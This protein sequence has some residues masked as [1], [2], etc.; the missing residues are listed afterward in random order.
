MLSNSHGLAPS[1]LQLLGSS[2]TGEALVLT[3]IKPKPVCP[4]KRQ[5]LSTSASQKPGQELQHREEH[6]KQPD[7]LERFSKKG[8]QSPVFWINEHTG[9]WSSINSTLLPFSICVLPLH[10]TSVM[11]TT[12]TSF[13]S[14]SL[15][16]DSL[17]FPFSQES[18][19]LTAG[20]SRF[21]PKGSVSK[22]AP[23]SQPHCCCEGT[24][25]GLVQ[26]L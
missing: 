25:K 15:W 7:F 23:C 26:P 5:L 9:Y 14:L 3:D 18:Q 24:S 16:G 6:Q 20:N 12:D 21:I 19:I 2:L 11:Q 22:K 10:F 17:L 8:L 4:A 1:A 13:T